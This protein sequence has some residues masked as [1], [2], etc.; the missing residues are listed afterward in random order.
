MNDPYIP[1][2]YF[3]N[4]KAAA[5]TLLE[6]KRAIIANLCAALEAFLSA[7]LESQLTDVRAAPESL[8]RGPSLDDLN[9]A[10][11]KV[12]MYSEQLSSAENFI[13]GRNLPEDARS[14]MEVQISPLRMILKEAEQFRNQIQKAMEEATPE[15]QQ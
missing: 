7:D 8:S 6:R 5:I 14:M 2:Y 1:Q 3:P 12:D 13:S 9:H 10:Q 15:A 4:G 11:E